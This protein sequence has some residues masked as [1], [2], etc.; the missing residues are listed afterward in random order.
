MSGRIWRPA[1]YDDSYQ[2][3]VTLR[4]ALIHSSNAATVRVSR[5]IGERNVV[6]AAQ[7]QGIRSALSP[8]PAIALGAV[9]VTPLELVTAYA[10]FAN[11]GMRVSPRL[12]QR[13]EAPDGTVLWSSE[14]E[15]GERVL[16]PRDA[17]ELTSML[18]GVVDHGT[19]TFGSRSLQLGGSAVHDAATAVWDQARGLAADWALV[20]GIDLLDGALSGRLIVR[21]GEFLTRERVDRSHDLV[22]RLRLDERRTVFIDTTS[23]ALRGELPGLSPAGGGGRPGRSPLPQARRIRCLVSSGW[24]GLLRR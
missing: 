24:V 14:V 20:G 13:I 10:A 9:E 1:N 5:A 8:V 2:G 12:V 6:L 11:G 21:S 17:Y 16:D 4:K 7:R 19:G 23:G 3:R 15:Q 22:R 18:R